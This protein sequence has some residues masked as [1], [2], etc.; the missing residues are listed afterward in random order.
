MSPGKQGYE[1][2]GSIIKDEEPMCIAPKIH[3]I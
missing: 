2:F 3:N 1:S